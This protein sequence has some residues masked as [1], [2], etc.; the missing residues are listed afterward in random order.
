MA[1]RQAARRPAVAGVATEKPMRH[2][3]LL[4]VRRA[5]NHPLPESPESPQKV[6]PEVTEISTT[7]YSE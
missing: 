1:R 3:V 6:Q 4:P 5:S 7:G 2:F